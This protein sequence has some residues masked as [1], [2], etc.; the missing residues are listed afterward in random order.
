MT[1][2]DRDDEYPLDTKDLR[3]FVTRVKAQSNID[4]ILSVCLAGHCGILAKQLR[5]LGVTQPLFG[6][7]M[8]DDR[9]EIAQAEGALRGAWYVTSSSPTPEFAAKLRG[10]GGDESLRWLTTLGHDALLLIAKGTKEDRSRAALNH[11]L[12][13]VRDFHGAAGKIT[14]SG[15]NDFLL[16]VG[17]QTIE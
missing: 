4:A 9:G 14:A 3:T 11:F 7:H 5:A 15:K 12:H 8:L 1:T 17:L 10:T 6:Y 16:P 2:G 13:A